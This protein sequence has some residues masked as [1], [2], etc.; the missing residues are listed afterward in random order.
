MPEFAKRVHSYTK[1]EQEFGDWFYEE[2]QA[3]LVIEKSGWPFDSTQRVAERL[4]QQRQ[5]SLKIEPVVI[6]IDQVTAFIVPGRYLY[7]SRELLQRLPDD[8]A[9]AFLIAHEM[10]HHDLG[11]VRL[12]NYSWLK[13]LP[14]DVYLAMLLKHIE[15]KFTS[16]EHESQADQYGLDLCLSA[17]YDGQKCLELFNVLEAHLLDFRNLEAVFGLEESDKPDSEYWLGSLGQWFTQTRQWG[18]KLLQSHP[19]VRGR[20]NQ[21]EEYL[22]SNHCQVTEK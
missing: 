9:I 1:Q 20:K 3:D 14:G 7:I 10:A 15:N 5:T 16:L 8:N 2:I 18:Q 12:S 13:S 6:W 11:H 21:L 22:N 19:H 17:G 4:N